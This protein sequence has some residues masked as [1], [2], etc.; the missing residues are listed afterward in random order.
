MIYD[1]QEVLSN[2]SDHFPSQ[3]NLNEYLLKEIQN[4]ILNV[5]LFTNYNTT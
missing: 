4:N 1:N 3:S 2:I 5:Q